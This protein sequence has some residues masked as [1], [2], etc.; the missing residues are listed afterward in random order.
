MQFS[1]ISRPASLELHP[2][3][4]CAYLN[5]GIRFNSSLL[6]KR[7]V[8]NL[9]EP[10]QDVVPD[11]R[12]YKDAFSTF[13]FASDLLYVKQ[14]GDMMGTR[15]DAPRAV[16]DEGQFEQMTERYESGGDLQTLLDENIGEDVVPDLI[17]KFRNESTWVM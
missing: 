17:E 3:T 9:R 15:P 4:V 6:K 8:E 16:Y 7:L 13:E 2:A 5:R 14:N 10:L 1:R 12:W 11:E